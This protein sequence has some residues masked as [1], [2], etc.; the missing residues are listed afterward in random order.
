MNSL[1]TNLTITLC[2]SATPRCSRQFFIYHAIFMKRYRFLSSL[3]THHAMTDAIPIT[4]ETFC[5]T[6]KTARDPDGLGITRGAQIDIGTRSSHDVDICAI[7]QT[8]TSHANLLMESILV[9][10]DDLPYG[11]SRLS[12]EDLRLDSDTLKPLKVYNHSP[13]SGA[14]VFALLPDADVRMRIDPKDS[15]IMHVSIKTLPVNLNE[16]FLSQ[17]TRQLRHYLCGGKPLVLEE[18]FH[19]VLDK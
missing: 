14:G 6:W 13:G 9:F 7:F 17:I 16:T 19:R 5:G 18:T 8:T 3:I 2:N 12:F 15:N 1:N 10:S 4:L 11:L